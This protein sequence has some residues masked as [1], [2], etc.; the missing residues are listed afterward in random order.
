[1]LNLS[2]LNGGVLGTGAGSRERA[3]GSAA[4][5][6]EA[7]G[8]LRTSLTKE[9]RVL[10]QTTAIG[11]L[12]LTQYATQKI[13]GLAESVGEM[14]GRV[15]T[16][17]YL[18]RDVEPVEV[19]GSCRLSRRIV[20][21]VGGAP[22]ADGYLDPTLAHRRFADPIFLVVGMAG[23]NSGIDVYTGPTPGDRIVIIQATDR[24]AYIAGV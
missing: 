23:E 18:N 2:L 13:A 10:G 24:I 7:A 12:R 20:V 1:M 16:R 9:G 6:V 11:V 4:Q 5:V 14:V 19:G 8:S 15:F 3:I 17:V 21:P 22:T